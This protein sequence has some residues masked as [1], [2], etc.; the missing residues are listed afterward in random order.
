[1]YALLLKEQELYRSFF[2]KELDERSTR[3]IT[4][5]FTQFP[6]DQPLAD[7]ERTSYKLAMGSNM[8]HFMAAQAR[9]DDFYMMPGLF[10]MMKCQV[11]SANQYSVDV[12]IELFDELRPIMTTDIL[13]EEF[14]IGKRPFVTKIV[15]LGRQRMLTQIIEEIQIQNCLHQFRNKVMLEIVQMPAETLFELCELILLRRAELVAIVTKLYGMYIERQLIATAL[16]RH[17]MLTKESLGTQEF[18][19]VPNWLEIFDQQRK[20]SAFW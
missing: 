13:M 10:N 12:Y 4:L 2:M 3:D 15:K 19:I 1:M 16:L 11:N 9:F 5:N 18:S 7:P 17:H 8:H 20:D 6:P 14:F